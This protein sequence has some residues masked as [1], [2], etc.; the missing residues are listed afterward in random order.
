MMES[1]NAPR[2][3]IHGDEYTG[4]LQ[5]ASFECAVLL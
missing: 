1:E 4:W 3:L 5:N 2:L